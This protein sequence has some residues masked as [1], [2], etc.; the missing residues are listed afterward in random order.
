MKDHPF[1][2]HTSSVF[3]AGPMSG[4]GNFNR[5]KFNDMA[6]VLKR[7]FDCDI[8]NPA[9]LEDGHE[10]A[11]YIDKCNAMLAKADYVVFLTGWKNSRGA[12]NEFK[13]AYKLGKRVLFEDQIMYIAKDME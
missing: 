1:I 6:S 2:K 8:L 7:C 12:V 5:D 9:T 4:I 13:L 10:Y 11:W 3:I